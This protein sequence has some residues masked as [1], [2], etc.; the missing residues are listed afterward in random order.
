MLVLRALAVEVCLTWGGWKCLIPSFPAQTSPVVCAF[1]L[2]FT[3]SETQWRM[4]AVYQHML[5]IN[6]ISN[7]L[8]VLIS[9][10]LAAL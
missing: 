10:Y 6:Y 1:R 9:S 2:H 5:V 4:F 8:G 7:I 3:S